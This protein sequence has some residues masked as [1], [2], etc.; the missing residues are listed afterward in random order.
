M[1]RTSYSCVCNFNSPITRRPGDAVAGSQMVVE[2]T[3]VLLQVPSVADVVIAEE[4]ATKL[5]LTL[6][7][8]D[9]DEEV[10]ITTTTANTSSII[11]YSYTS[12]DSYSQVHVKFYL[13][14]Q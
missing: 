11:M 6:G 8:E 3:A 10:Y 14:I 13:F 4:D 7:P 12:C 9:S 1:I 5:A 2:L